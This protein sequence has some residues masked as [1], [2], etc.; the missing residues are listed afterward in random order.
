MKRIG[1]EIQV[2]YGVV[3][4]YRLAR[5]VCDGFLCPSFRR[6]YSSQSL[7][8]SS[9]SLFQL[10]TVKFLLFCRFYVLYSLHLIVEF[11]YRDN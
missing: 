10:L 7:Q 1:Y 4:T 3:G 9:L 11:Y 2:R 8:Y 5:G 6:S